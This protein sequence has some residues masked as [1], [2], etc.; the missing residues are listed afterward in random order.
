[1]YYILYEKKV[2]FF[3]LDYI[4]SIN[5]NNL[6]TL[7]PINN[8]IIVFIKQNNDGIN[9]FIFLEKVPNFLLTMKN[10]FKNFILINTEQMTRLDKKKIILS[11]SK[12]IKIIDY[13]FANY[14]ILKEYKN[15][16]YLPYQV[17]Y[18]E[19][20]NYE[21]TNT[22]AMIG[23][24][25]AR[26]SFILNQIRSKENIDLIHGWDKERD[27]IL[28]RYKILVNIHFNKDYNIFEQLRCNRCI[29]NKIIII[30]EKSFDEEYEL[31]DYI[32]VC[33]YDDIVN[34]VIEVSKNY[35][36]Y[37]NKIFSNFN[38][39][40]IDNKLKNIYENFLSI[41]KN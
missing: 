24:H 19:I 20:Y 33:E 32:I 15:I 6:L 4:N 40:E 12:E 18:N 10:S 30:T 37:Y 41:T 34:K 29:Y 21:K 14:D 1:M 38:I 25:S 39:E 31:K 22:I 23:S 11:Y 9:K 35:D 5:K 2:L 13:S 27:E 7:V 16:F 8:K 28:F 17:N 3:F 26:R 36:Y